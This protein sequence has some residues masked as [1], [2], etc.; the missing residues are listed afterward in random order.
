M[1]DEFALKTQNWE[2]KY[3]KFDS[4][5]TKFTVQKV[6]T[7]IRVTCVQENSHIRTSIKQFLLKY[8]FFKKL[9]QI[10]H[11]QKKCYF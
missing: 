5:E 2:G 9:P 10:S 1:L 3:V 6:T 7:I 4:V 11:I 8:R